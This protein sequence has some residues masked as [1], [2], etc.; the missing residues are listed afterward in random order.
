MRQV[1]SAYRSMLPLLPTGARRFLWVYVVISSALAVLDIA[2]LMLLAVS[3]TGMVQGKPLQLPFI[4][5]IEPDSTIWLLVVV[6][7]LIVVKSILAAGLQ[8]IATRRF[9]AY[10]LRIG[11]QLF[12]AY[13]TA[14]WTERLRR[15]TAQLV[16]L[17]DVGIAAIIGGFLIPLITLPSMLATFVAVVVVLV[18]SQPMTAAITLVYLGLIALLLYWLVSRRA[19]VAGRVNRDYSFKVAELMTDMVSA[20]K[21]ITLRGSA[22]SVA[23]VVHDNRI[24]T[25]RAR[26]NLSFLGAVPRFVFDAAL[27]GGFLLI[28]GFAWLIGGPAEAFSAIALFGVA[29]FR[30]VPSLTGFQSVVTQTQAS[31]PIVTAV[32][33][34]IRDA[35][36]H[37]LAAEELGRQPLG[38]APKRLELRDVAFTY[39]GT[40]LEAVH[41]IDLDVPLGSSLGLVGSSGAGKS[42]LVDVLLGLLTPTRG[43][44]TID[45][46]P[47]HDVLRDWRSRVGYVPQEVALF[48]GSVAQ[49]VALTWTTDFDEDRVR[50]ALERAQLLE[51]IESRPGGI[52]APVGDRGMSLSGGQR[53][54]L[55]IARALYDD[56]LVLVMDEATSA[57]DTKTESEVARAIRELHGSVT[58]IAIAHR[59]STIRESDQVC[60]M[61]DGTI[62]ASGTF[63]EVVRDEPDFA[64]QAALAGLTEDDR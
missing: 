22:R 26:A 1:L 55:G 5:A 37:T 59:L 8:W 39:P 43:S 34:D 45:G 2:A 53:Q 24:H 50:R 20:L 30:L 19:T 11:D 35:E 42:T 46:T 31:V 54:R 52:H 4:G 32:I 13:I 61:R 16:R 29:G 36:G 56:P 23:E 14:P 18:V 15:N 33:R 17:A 41:A 62:V 64:E 63:D 12:D 47:L 6:C 10:E 21:E 28:G 7:S 44:V 3:L 9:A 25:T 40:S 27:V 49:N 57:L 38:S 48:A 58:V 51:V 60:F